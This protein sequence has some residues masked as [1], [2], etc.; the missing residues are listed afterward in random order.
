MPIWLRNFT[1][2]K[3]LEFLQKQQERREQAMNEAQGIES[4]TPQ[5]TGPQGPNINSS[6]YSTTVS[7]K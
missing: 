4:A 6:A 2:K 1:Y 7:K 5:N 3:I